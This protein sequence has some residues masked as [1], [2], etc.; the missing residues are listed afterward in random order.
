M[1]LGTLHARARFAPVDQSRQRKAPIGAL[2]VTFFKRS[3]AGLKAW[4]AARRGMNELM[5][6]DDRTLADIGLIRADIPDAVR[7]GRRYQV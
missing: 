7:R 5:A 2:L 1:A 6:L 3:I 4:H